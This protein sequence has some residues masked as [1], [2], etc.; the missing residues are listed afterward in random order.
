MLFGNMG[1]GS[2]KYDGGSRNLYHNFQ[3][4]ESGIFQEANSYALAS[5]H[6]A[7]NLLKME[8]R[9]SKSGSP[10][11]K[12]VHCNVHESNL[13]SGIDTFNIRITFESVDGEG[14]LTNAFHFL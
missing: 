6:V 9:M 7:Y 13:G 5:A 14:G 8:K 10:S 1:E 12:R 4:Q 2:G 3:C 11:N